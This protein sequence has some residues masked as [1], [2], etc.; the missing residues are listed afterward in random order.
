MDSPLFNGKG[1]LNWSY[2]ENA[3]IVSYNYLYPKLIID[4]KISERELS[5]LSN[6]QLLCV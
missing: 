5:R 6:E 3:M 4:E 2:D 1:V